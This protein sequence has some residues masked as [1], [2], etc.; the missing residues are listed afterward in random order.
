M[1][2]GLYLWHWPVYV[3]L[4]PDRTGWDGLA[5]L[6]PRLALSTALAVAS[7]RLVENPIRR[8]ATWARTRRGIPLLVASIAAVAL[9]FGLL[10]APATE[11]AG[12]DPSSVRRRRA[13][14]DGR[15]AHHPGA[16]IDGGR[17]RPSD[18]APHRRRHGSA[19]RAGTGDR[20]GGDGAAGDRSA[21][22]APDRAAGPDRRCGLGR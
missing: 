2:Y 21:D 18:P 12:F 6:V 1:S 22:D 19:D 15:R 9:V 17:G 4:S 14:H 7:Y 20:T 3:V 5:L 16:D 8:D 11:I 13:G 10:P